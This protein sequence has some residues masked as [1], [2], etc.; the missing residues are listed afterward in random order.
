M[1][2]ALGNPLV[3]EVGDLLAEDEIRQYRRATQAGLEGGLVVR[4][5][6]A[7][8]GR[9]RVRARRLAVAPES[10]GRRR[11]LV[12]VDGGICLETIVPLGETARRRRRVERKVLAFAVEP[13][14]CRVVLERLVRV[15]WTLLS[16][17][18]AGRGVSRSLRIP[19]LEARWQRKC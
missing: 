11:R 12:T 2:D 10:A 5:R 7:L 8:V 16:R 14:E 3:I 9:Q 1:Y 6:H 19:P 17:E 15:N 4:E 13:A 18:L